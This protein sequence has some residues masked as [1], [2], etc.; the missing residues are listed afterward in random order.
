VPKLA[1]RAC[2]RQVYAAGAVDSLFAEERRCPR[3]G[4]FM[5][6]ERRWADRRQLVRRVN[7]PDSPGP[8]AGTPERREA[9]RRT[10]GRRWS[11]GARGPRP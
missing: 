7:P 3:C 10:S 1:C 6:R 4:A 5:D 9:D 8:P 2:G 11:D